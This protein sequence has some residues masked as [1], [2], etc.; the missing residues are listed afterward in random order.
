MWLLEIR[1]QRR[2][3][4]SYSVIGTCYQQDLSLLM[5]T[6]ITWLREVC[7]S[8]FSVEFSPLL[9]YWKEVSVQ[10][11]PL[12]R[13][14]CRVSV[15][16]VWNSSAPEISLFSHVYSVIYFYQYGLTSICL[17]LQVIIHHC[18]ILVLGIGHWEL[19]WLAPV[20]LGHFPHYCGQVFFPSTSLFSGPT[21]CSRFIF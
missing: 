21:R 4:S 15:Y 5:L 20:F 18:F 14:L 16:I 12:S 19:F 9:L 10:P 7:M 17:T 6:L 1:P 13:K 3:F 11:T 8:H 2:S